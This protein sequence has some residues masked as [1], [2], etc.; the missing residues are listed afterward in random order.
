MFNKKKLLEAEEGII[1]K[2]IT[3]FSHSKCDLFDFTTMY[4]YTYVIKI[5][6]YLLENK[7]VDLLELRFFSI[8]YILFL[9]Q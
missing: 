1:N 9:I 5:F 2:V 3:K 6:K 7:E 8:H 4:G